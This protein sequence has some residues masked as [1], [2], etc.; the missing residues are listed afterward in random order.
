[1]RS[2]C[3]FNL[4]INHICIG[5]YLFC[6]HSACWVLHHR[7]LMSL[8]CGTFTKQ[9]QSSCSPIRSK[10][11]KTFG[12]LL[13]RWRCFRALGRH[14]AMLPQS[15]VSL[16]PPPSFSAESSSAGLPHAASM[17]MSVPT[18]WGAF[19]FLFLEQQPMFDKILSLVQ[20]QNLDAL[21]SLMTHLRAQR[22]TLLL[23]LV[24]VT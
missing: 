19:R 18:D 9:T 13:T 16:G 23:R 24:E 5:E 2:H 4:L 22:A 6:I 15:L 7:S 11:T 21:S 12:C 14:S 8:S 10:H 20:S 1:M 17:S 3:I